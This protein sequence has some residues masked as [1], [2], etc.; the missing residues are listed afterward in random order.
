MNTNTKSKKLSLSK[1]SLRDL[2][3]AELQQVDGG[4]PNSAFSCDGGETM[5]TWC[6]TN[7]S[8]RTSEYYGCCF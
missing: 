7:A 1:E 8:C 4:A 6:Y 2:S 5:V 3:E